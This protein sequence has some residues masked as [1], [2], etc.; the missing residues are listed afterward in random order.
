M[1]LYVICHFRVQ[2]LRKYLRSEI[3]H[4]N[5][6]TFGLQILSSFQTDKS[7]T[8]HHGLFHMV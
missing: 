5:R 2:D 3:D 7:G 4:G 6:D 8:D 1:F